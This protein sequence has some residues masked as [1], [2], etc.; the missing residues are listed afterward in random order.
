VTKQQFRER[1]RALSECTGD[2]LAAH[3]QRVEDL[4]KVFPHSICFVA[5]GERKRLCFDYALGIDAGIVDLTYSMIGVDPRER[6]SFVTNFVKA[7]VLPAL[8]PVRQEEAQDG[9]IM[10][11]FVNNNPTHA[12]IFKAG[13]VI[14]KWGHC[15]V[16]EHEDSEVPSTYGDQM[17]T[18]AKPDRHTMTMKFIE[19]T[20]AYSGYRVF[21][22][23]FEQKV[24]NYNASRQA[25]QY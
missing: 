16:Y 2:E 17:R 9:D 14:S 11:Y 25:V 22:S 19:Y 13:R 7:L 1:L 18:F 20:R 5:Q 15:P 10:V 8:D 6:D 4:Q 23:A 3:R 24:R 12:G 21:K